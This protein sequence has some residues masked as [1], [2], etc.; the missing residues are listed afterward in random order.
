MTKGTTS[1][2]KRHNKTHTL[3]RRCGRSSYHIQKSRCASCAYPSKKKRVYGWSEKAH[4]RHTTGTGRMKHL[5][6]KPCKHTFCYNCAKELKEC[7]RCNSTFEK[8]EE[9]KFGDLFLCAFDSKRYS[10]EGCYSS[11]KSLRDLESHVNFRHKM[12]PGSGYYPP[13]L[14]ILRSSQV[15]S[16]S[17]SMQTEPIE[18][19]LSIKSE[20]SPGSNT[21][22]HDPAPNDT[23]NSSTPD[24]KIQSSSS[25][26]EPLITDTPPKLS[27][28]LALNLQESP[29]QQPSLH[30]NMYSHPNIPIPA[31]NI[32]SQSNN[33]V[34]SL[35]QFSIPSHT[36]HHPP[37]PIQPPMQIPQRMS[38]SQP[39]FHNNM[40]HPLP[41]TGIG[42]IPTNMPGFVPNYRTQ[43]NNTSHILGYKHNPFPSPQLHRPFM[44]ERM[45]NMSGNN[46][47]PTHPPMYTASRPS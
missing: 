46:P 9:C 24:S 30:S 15:N 35:S 45:P 25:Q 16:E 14:K 21:P 34:L 4:R 18:L 26:I 7:K 10:S 19:N 43:Y 41:P 28:S 8:V 36:L 20:I 5:K 11:Y 37:R 40:G 27:R 13:F 22:T 29:P 3:C 33:E 6:L 42:V 1:F 38:H 23:S 32:H 47:I 2:G 17:S 44:P 31:L 12:N 39:P